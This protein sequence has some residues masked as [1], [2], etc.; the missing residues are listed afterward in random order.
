[1]DTS[2]SGGLGVG[3]EGGDRPPQEQDELGNPHCLKDVKEE[4]KTNKV[5]KMRKKSKIFFW[6]ATKLCIMVITALFF[7]LVSLNFH[8]FSLPNKC[9][10]KLYFLDNLNLQEKMIYRFCC[11]I[12][13]VYKRFS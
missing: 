13:L 3:G 12:C 5:K 4:E 11:V 6:H 2:A 9:L 10:P 1:M 7:K 8:G